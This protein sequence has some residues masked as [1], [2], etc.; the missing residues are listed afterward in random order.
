MSNFLRLALGVPKVFFAACIHVKH[1]KQTRSG[2]AFSHRDRLLLEDLAPSVCRYLPETMVAEIRLFGFVQ[3]FLARILRSND[4]YS[5]S[6]CRRGPFRRSVREKHTI[7][8]H[9]FDMDVT[10]RSEVYSEFCGKAGWL[11]RNNWIAVW[12]IIELREK[13]NLLVGFG[14]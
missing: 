11:M 3:S 9:N 7:S 12:Y 1:S 14:V 10:E 13:S 5:R 8:R 6:V 4:S 2:C